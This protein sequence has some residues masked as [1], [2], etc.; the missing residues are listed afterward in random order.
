MAILSQKRSRR[1]EEI[2]VRLQRVPSIMNSSRNVSMKEKAPKSGV[3]KSK[4]GM[5]VGGGSYCRSV[6]SRAGFPLLPPRDAVGLIPRVLR[7]RPWERGP[8]LCLHLWVVPLRI[9]GSEEFPK[10][11]DGL[12]Q[13][14]P[15]V[16][17]PFWG[18]R[19]SRHPDRTRNRCTGPRVLGERTHQSVPFSHLHQPHTPNHLGCDEESPEHQRP[20]L[21]GHRG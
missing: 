16:R 7:R 21:F 20:L 1:Y 8:R 9:Q 10:R 12:V 3:S 19:R 5:E 18:F 6:G 4:D 11:M 2:E 17:L 15:K 13:G 14:R